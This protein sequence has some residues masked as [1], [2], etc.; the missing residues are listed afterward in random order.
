MNR[1][2]SQ[3]KTI[4]NR[5]W[6]SNRRRIGQFVGETIRDQMFRNVDRGRDFKGD[7]YVGYAERTKKDRKKLGYPINKVDFQRSKKRIKDALVRYRGKATE[8]YWAQREMRRGKTVGQV[9]Y[10]HQHGMGKN[11]P[12]HIFPNRTADIPDSIHKKVGRKIA[13]VLNEPVN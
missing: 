12:R 6:H 5:A 1:L 11:P 13:E 9:F 2:G 3:F 7:K 8:I 4:I 10:F